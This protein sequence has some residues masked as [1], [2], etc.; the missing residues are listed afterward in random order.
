MLKQWDLRKNLSGPEWIVVDHKTKKRKAE[1]KETEVYLNECRIP[2][3]K[4]KSELARRFPP[5]YGG[6][7]A[8]GN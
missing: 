7:Y 1:N 2:P 6:W 8:T 3:K 4:V 5:S